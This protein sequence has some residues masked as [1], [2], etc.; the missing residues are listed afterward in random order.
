MLDDNH[1]IQNEW[2]H[3]AGGFLAEHQPPGVHLILVT[4]ADPPLPL[5]RL[6]G[7]GQIAEIRDHDLRFTAEEAARFLNEVVELDLPAEAVSTLEWR[8]EGWMA[9]W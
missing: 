4:R 5:A 3:Q 2:V 8:T 9:G 1:L 6:R 7:R